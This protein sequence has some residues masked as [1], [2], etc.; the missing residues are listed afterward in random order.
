M[1]TARQ[2]IRTP[3][4]FIANDQLDDPYIYRQ[5][6]GK[7][8]PRAVLYFF[9]NRADLIDALQGEVYPRPSLLLMDWH[10][11]ARE[12]YAALAAL[13]RNPAW[14]T[15]PVVIL[16]APDRPV[17]EDQCRQTGYEL[18]LPRQTGFDSLVGQLNGLMLALL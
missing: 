13:G 10:M 7:A 15:I 12:G 16:S 6:F 18:V 3:I 17:D 2:L 8:N 11:V 9:L 1:E 14:Q 5:A 4:I